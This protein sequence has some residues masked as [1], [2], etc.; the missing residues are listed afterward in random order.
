MGS[1]DTIVKKRP[2]RSKSGSSKK[3]RQWGHNRATGK[4][5]RQ[6]AR[7]AKNKEKRWKKHLVN[8]PNDL[9]AIQYIETKG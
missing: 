3:D 8:H 9:Q 4:Y 7:T 2:S 6:R 1:I 5:I